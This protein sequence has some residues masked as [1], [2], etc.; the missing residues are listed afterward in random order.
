MP[1]EPWQ[2][3]EREAARERSAEASAQRARFGEYPAQ[4]E[5]RP[6]P[7]AAASD[8]APAEPEQTSTGR[9]IL[10]WRDDPSGNSNFRGEPDRQAFVAAVG[11]CRY[12]WRLAS[13]LIDGAWEGVA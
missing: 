7:A 9:R 2:F 12:E 10:A 3:E 13:V 6:Q 5:P 4:P 8:P 11:W 1:L